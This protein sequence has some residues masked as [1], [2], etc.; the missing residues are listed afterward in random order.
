MM[1]DPH[2]RARPTEVANPIATGRAPA[3]SGAS[4]ERMITFRERRPQTSR[5]GVVTSF[6]NRLQEMKRSLY[7]FACSTL[8]ALAFAGCQA[9]EAARSA[10]MADADASTFAFAGDFDGPLGIQLWTVREYTQDDVRDALQ[11]V[12][13]MGFREVELA[14]TYG[15]APA[16]FRQ[17]LDSLDL[18]PTAGHFSYEQ[19]RD[20]LDSVLDQAEALGLEYLGVAWIPHPADRPFD[21]EM[22][23]QAAAD[24]NRFGSA[25]AE[26]G[27][28]FYYH[29]HGYEFQPNADGTT[30]FDVL[31]AET[32]PDNVKFE[33]DVFWTALPG[34]DPAELLRKYPDRWELMHVKDMKQ[35]WPLGDH[36]GSASA[37]ADVPVGTGQID[38]AEVLRAAEE[39]G[40][41]R[42]YIE[43]ESTT[44]LENVPQS[45]EYLESIT[46]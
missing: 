12:R 42:Y 16:A 13:D 28:T 21:D 14:G 31:V 3:T 43:D 11:R 5:G 18:E 33:M 15:M 25:A 8:V 2:I 19:F 9:D 24:F 22:A 36:S 30:P 38:Y 23:R 41:D 32:D 10:A 37:E 29:V 1:L 35:G 34:V 6:T 27:M 44:P 17:L 39:I 46:Y 7:Y 4:L 40:M 45:I 20:S 26:R